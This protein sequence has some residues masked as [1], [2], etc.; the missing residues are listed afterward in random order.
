MGR[1]DADGDVV[2]ELTEK[3]AD[4]I[5]QIER[6]SRQTYAD[7]N[8]I[9]VAGGADNLLGHDCVSVGA[10]SLE[11]GWLLS[12]PVSNY[13]GLTKTNDPNPPREARRQSGNQ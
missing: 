3:T 7:V 4:P 12:M 5:L 8:G 13:A 11:L 9:K 6:E 1:G 2:D 10:S